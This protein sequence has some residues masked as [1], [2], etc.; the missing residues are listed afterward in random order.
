M[1]IL[2]K[3]PNGVLEVQFKSMSQQSE[4]WSEKE[5]ARKLQSAV[6]ARTDLETNQDR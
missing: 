5:F 2:D 1:T 4:F 6:Q 3:G